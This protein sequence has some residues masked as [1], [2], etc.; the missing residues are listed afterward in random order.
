MAVG[1]QDRVRD[2]RGW[3]TGLA[4][5][6]VVLALGAGACSSSDDGDGETTADTAAEAVATDVRMQNME[7]D[8]D[9]EPIDGGRLIWG[10]EAETDGWNPVVNRW[11]LSGHM[12]GSA[13][14]DPLASIDEQG[15]AV[16]YLAESITSNDDATEWDITLRPGVQFH[17]G[18]PVVAQ[19]VA[20]TLNA[21]LGSVITSSALAAVESVEPVDELT[22][23]VTMSEPW[24]QFP[25]VLTTQVGYVVPTV[26]T[27]DLATTNAPIGTGPFVFVDWD[28]NEHVTT[29]RNEDYWQEGKPH[30]AELEFRPIADA[31]ERTQAL[32][33]GEIDAMN[34]WSAADIAF[35]RTQDVKMVE[36]GGGEERHLVLNTA[37]P[38]FD[39]VDA[40]LA[41][42]HAVDVD[43]L[44]AETGTDDVLVASRGPWA[45]G[46]LGYREDS[47]A[48]GY[49]PELARQHAQAYQDRTGQPLTFT[50][51]GASNIE[52]LQRQN[53]L[54]TM[55]E[56][57]G[58]IVEVQTVSQ[59][60]LI[61][62]SALGLF[63]ASDFRNF[64]ASD[65]DGEAV[66]WQGRTIPEDPAG[67][68]INFTRFGDPAIDAALVEGR[69][70]TDEAVRDEAYAEVARLLNE[71]APIVF[72]E[73]VTWAVVADPRVH[74]IGAGANGSMQTLGTKTWVADL[75][76]G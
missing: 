47:G 36:Y 40:R 61:L 67:V 65:P 32:L 15:A 26:M 4:A 69:S 46:Q 6:L 51:L 19:N 28:P 50:Y 75:W 52:D 43:R 62:S 25:Y 54:K 68:S 59:D 76:V 24:F 14:F 55:W 10:L 22:T 20:D 23:R 72:L 58:I 53:S 63:Q 31:G 33:N 16:P 30:L 8:L 35:L 66:W 45:P 11:A 29:R 70:T 38:P 13:I 48:P 39:D 5:V 64:G 37:T 21:H 56:E 44:L 7:G 1:Q 27:Q 12:V 9:G 74:G 42:A 17:D 71:Q 2:R 18:S 34:T 41:V 3:P 60:D 49:D 57:A 73:R